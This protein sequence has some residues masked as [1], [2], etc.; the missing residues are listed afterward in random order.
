MKLHQNMKI[1]SLLMADFVLLSKT[2]RVSTYSIA[3]LGFVLKDR[4]YRFFVSFISLEETYSA[5][6]KT[7]YVVKDAIQ[8]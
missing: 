6:L 3:V 5:L 1:Y 7:F 8:D 2:K 4:V